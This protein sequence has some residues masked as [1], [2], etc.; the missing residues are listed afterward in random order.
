MILCLLAPLHAAKGLF[1]GELLA[2]DI[3]GNGGIVIHGP[4]DIISE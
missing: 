2:E 3:I 4:N 1:E